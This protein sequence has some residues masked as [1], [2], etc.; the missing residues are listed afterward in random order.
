MANTII[1]GR[2]IQWDVY[3]GQDKKETGCRYKWYARTYDGNLLC[4]G[5]DSEE[6]AGKEAI[7]V[8]HENY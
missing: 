4:E 7:R 2:C 1:N 5:Y 3:Y 8:I 6:E